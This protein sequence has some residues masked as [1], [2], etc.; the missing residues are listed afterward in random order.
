[1]TVAPPSRTTRAG[2]R[3]ADLSGQP[4]RSDLAIPDQ[5]GPGG[6]GAR[7]HRDHDSI[8]DDQVDPITAGLTWVLPRAMPPRA[9]PL[10]AMLPT[11]T[12]WVPTT[13]WIVT[14]WVRRT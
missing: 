4:H 6:P 10:T 5:H 8:L 14:G 11:A 2:G 1:M 9:M 7:R 3:R 12:G 13:P